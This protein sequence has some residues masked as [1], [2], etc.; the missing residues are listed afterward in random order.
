MLFY[1]EF[2]LRGTY[3]LSNFIFSIV[4]KFQKQFFIAANIHNKHAYK[5]PTKYF[6]Q[7][8]YKQTELHKHFARRF[9]KLP[10][11]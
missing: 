2:V 9:P 1:Y 6:L 8:Y 10:K 11:S 7:L 5:I 3:I 4:I